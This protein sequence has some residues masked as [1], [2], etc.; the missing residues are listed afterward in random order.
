MEPLKKSDSR[1]ENSEYGVPSHCES[2]LAYSN[3][4][5]YSQAEQDSLRYDTKNNCVLCGQ[6]KPSPNLNN[7]ENLNGNDSQVLIQN[8][9]E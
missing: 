9:R 8:M 6:S 2:F 7:P 1:D 5:I 4:F 3:A